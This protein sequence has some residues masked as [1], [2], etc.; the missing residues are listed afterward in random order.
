MEK[1]RL[2][3][4]LT[5]SDEEFCSYRMRLGGKHTA[6]QQQEVDVHPGQRQRGQ[7]LLA[8]CC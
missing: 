5:L 8:I 1:F 6:Q 3:A 4:V 7:E 2:C